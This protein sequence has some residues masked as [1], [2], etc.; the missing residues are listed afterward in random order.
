MVALAKRQPEVKSFVLKEFSLIQQNLDGLTSFMNEK[1]IGESTKRQ[2]FIM[3]ST[4]N[5]ALMLAESLKDMKSKQSQSSSSS[6]KKK[7]SN[8]QCNN[9]G[10]NKKKKS[11]PKLP[12]IKKLQESL[13]EQ[14]K[15]AGQKSKKGRGDR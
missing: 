7:K 5:L 10:N 3:T 14:I 12:D 6:K 15:K 2:Q 11:Q 13:N 4:N 1:N 9:P 8:S